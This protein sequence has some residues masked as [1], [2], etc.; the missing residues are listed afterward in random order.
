MASICTTLLKLGRY[1][2]SAS[3]NPR[4]FATGASGY[5]GGNTIARI[6]KKHS[7]WDVVVLVRTEEEKEKIN[8]AWPNAQVVLGA[9][10][11]AET[12]SDEA[13]KAKAGGRKFWIYG[14]RHEIS[15]HGSGF[16]GNRL[17]AFYKPNLC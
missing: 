1:S 11:D 8:A 2:A 14:G 6:V 7:D 10:D 4:V 17:F 9:L 16:L 13:S 3:R 15:L 12:L 5:L